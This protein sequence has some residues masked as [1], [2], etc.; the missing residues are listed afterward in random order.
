MFEKLLELL[1]YRGFVIEIPVDLKAVHKC[2]L[3]EI[4]IDELLSVIEERFIKEVLAKC[5]ANF[6]KLCCMSLDV[7][8]DRE[9]V[10]I[11]TNEFEIALK[12]YILKFI[13]SP[14]SSKVQDLLLIYLEYESR[15]MD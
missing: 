15:L 2:V 3:E 7:G 8:G 11:V 13:F 10:S 6:S 12:G 9:N 1:K 5:V 4:T 14:H